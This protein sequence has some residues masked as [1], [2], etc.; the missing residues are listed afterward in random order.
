ME[1]HL[2]V[3]GDLF[4]GLPHRPSK[5]LSAQERVPRLLTARSTLWIDLAATDCE[6]DV[7]YLEQV[8]RMAAQLG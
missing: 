4:P 5:R 2:L 7:L 1:R 8:L 6:L 3:G